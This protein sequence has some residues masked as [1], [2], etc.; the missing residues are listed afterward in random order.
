MFDL[1]NEENDTKDQVQLSTIYYLG[2]LNLYIYIYIRRS[3]TNQRRMPFMM[4]VEK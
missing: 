3:S 2:I 4:K 1:D